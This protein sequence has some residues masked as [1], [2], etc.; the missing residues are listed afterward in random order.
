MPDVLKSCLDWW[1]YMQ[2]YYPDLTYKFRLSPAD[3]SSAG[4]SSAGLSTQS[5][6]LIYG[7]EVIEDPSLRSGEVLIA[8]NEKS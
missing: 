6:D 1:Q 4:L 5:R 8:W 7:I 3:L 2:S